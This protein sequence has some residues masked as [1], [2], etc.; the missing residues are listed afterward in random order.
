MVLAL[1]YATFCCYCK[2]ISC[3]RIL[4]GLKRENNTDTRSRN[5]YCNIRGM[6]YDM[7]EKMMK[8][9]IK[10][11]I[12]ALLSFIGI[13]IYT[14]TIYNSY[15][16]NFLISLIPVILFYIYYNYDLKLSKRQKKYSFMLLLYLL[17]FQ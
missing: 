10:C 17:C 16:Y 15:S 11:L 6:Y 14:K 13:L 4:L 8:K 12:E 9:I 2:Y 3:S 5:I 7:G 1:F